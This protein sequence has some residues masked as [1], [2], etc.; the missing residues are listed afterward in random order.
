MKNK[1]VNNKKNIKNI[2][3]NKKL[4]IILLVVSLLV[5]SIVIFFLFIFPSNDNVYY[6]S[7]N[8]LEKNKLSV[9][10]DFSDNKKLFGNWSS[11]YTEIYKNDELSVKLV[12]T[13]KYVI[14][15]SKDKEMDVCFLDDKL[16]CYLM[17]Y[18]F[19]DDM[20]DIEFSGTYLNNKSQI[21]IEDNQ[22]IVKNIVNEN[23][24][25]MLYF[26]KTD[27]K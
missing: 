10:K 11:L 15:I 16:K 9:D 5:I 1:K 3:N 14:K 18:T 22:L 8:G 27:N 20:L 23:M 6:E 17:K 24:Y 21:M 7:T 2:I 12:N 13:G 19:I 26:E 25:T 4:I